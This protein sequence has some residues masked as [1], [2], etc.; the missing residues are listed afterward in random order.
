MSSSNFNIESSNFEKKTPNNGIDSTISNLKSRLFDLEQQEKDRNALAQKLSQLKKEFQILSTTKDRLEQE[1]KQKDDS[2]NQ[3]INSLRNDNENL[4]LS[5]NEKMAL[6]K[7]LFT[8]NDELEKEIEARDNEINDLK[9]KLN[10]MNNQLG[11]SLVDKGDLENQVQK[12]KAIKNSQ[13]N[14]INKLTKENKN[15]SEIITDQ[16][17]K[18]QRAQEE[19]AMMNN[20]SNENDADIQN[21]NIKLR[22]LM[23]DI[24][25]TQNGLNKN[26]LD[27]HNLDEK[28]GELNCQ[29][30]N[31]KCENANLNDNILREKALRADKERQNQNLNSLIIDHE[32]Q[33]ND[34]NNRYNNLNAQYDI[35][36]TDSKNSQ[37]Q[38]DK[39][40]GHIML[41][42]QQNQKLLDELDN[43]KCQDLK[44]QNLLSRKE[45]SSMILR[46]VHGCIQQGAL[47][48]EKI[49][50]D[51]IGYA[52]G[53]LRNNTKEKFRSNS[54]TY[55]Y[56]NQNDN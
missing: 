38:N 33:I 21:L 40:K 48:L 55:T 26:N 9:N 51:P 42:S 31:L 3:K 30:E 22:G 39:L 49:E 2:Y 41:L 44:M 8:E 56:V 45:Q 28:L 5:Y 17:K 4:Q 23:D 43:V 46:G 14:D 36:T 50:G 24:S 37:I 13:I 20:K 32:N 6:N 25:T 35:A 16:D 53:N 27:N 19:I 29:C 12:L 54:P 10:D 15:L 34:L 7:K 47:C 52:R 11:Q 18:L 1:L